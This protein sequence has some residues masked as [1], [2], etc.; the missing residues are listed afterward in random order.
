MFLVGLQ[1][2]AAPA[3]RHD[4]A[5]NFLVAGAILLECATDQMY[6]YSS[7]R[8]AILSVHDRSLNTAVSQSCSVF[9]QSNT[10]IVSSGSPEV[11]HLAS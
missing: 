3:S 4:Q 1:Y 6:V 5:V 10:A 2:M 8:R 9:A 11:Q 7:S